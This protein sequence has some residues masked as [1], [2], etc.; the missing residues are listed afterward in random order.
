MRKSRAAYFTALLSAII[1]ITSCSWFN[2][3]IQSPVYFPFPTVTA[4]L[5]G[6]INITGAVPHEIL[7]CVNCDVQSRAASASRSA[8]PSVPSTGAGY[9]YYATVT[10][11]NGIKTWSGSADFTSLPAYSISGLDVDTL[12]QIEIGIK[13]DSTGNSVLKDTHTLTASTK[14]SEENPVYSHDFELKPMQTGGTTP[15]S[16]SIFLD[17][18]L[19]AGSE[20]TKCITSLSATEYNAGS[21]AITISTTA[22][23]G[24]YVVEFNFYS[25]ASE[26]LYSFTEAINVFDNLETDTWVRNGGT[27]SSPYLVEETDVSG[28]VTKCRITNA[29]VQAFRNTTLYVK[30]SG[31]NTNGTGTFFNPLQSI[32]GAIAKMYDK[33]LD[34]RI[35]VMDSPSGTMVSIPS[36]FTK[37]TNG[38]NHAKS[39]TICGYDGPDENGIPQNII[40]GLGVNAQPVIITFS[41]VPLIF[42]NLKL[43]N[44]KAGIDIYNYNTEVTL[45]DG[46]Y[47]TGNT[48][49]VKSNSFSM[50]GSAYIASDNAVSLETALTGVTYKIKVKGALT[51]HSSTDKIKVIPTSYTRGSAIVEADGTNV[52][53]LTSVKDCFEIV[54]T[55]W[56]T[57]LPADKSKIVINAPYFVAPASSA[58]S[59]Y[60]NG[61]DTTGDGS[62]ANPYESIYRVTNDIHYNNIALDYTIKVAGTIDGYQ[63]ILGTGDNAVTSANAA[64]ITIMGARPLLDTGKPQDWISC[65]S[66]KPVIRY[67]ATGVPLTLKNIC[68]TNGCT[69]LSLAS[70]GAVYIEEGTEITNNTY[71]LGGISSSQALGKG[72]CMNGG[73]LYLRGGEIHDNTMNSDDNSYAYISGGIHNENGIIYMSGGKIYKNMGKLGGGIYN[74]G[75]EVYIYGSAVIGKADATQCAQNNPTTNSSNRAVSGGGIYNTGTRTKDGNIYQAKVYIG[76]KPDEAGNIVVD[77]DFTGGIYY[78]YATSDGGAIY[79]Y[80]ST[81]NEAPEVHI[82]NGTIAY[83]S[84]QKGG[85]INLGGVNNTYCKVYL[86]GGVIKENYAS[87]STA[88]GAIHC[89]SGTFDVSLSGSV[90]IPA[91]VTN[92]E[93]PPVL[94]KGVGRNDIYLNLTNSHKLTVAGKLE[95]PAGSGGITATITPSSYTADTEVLALRTTPAPNP[96][97]T[98]DEA[99]ACFAVTPQVVGDVTTN[100]SV[101]EGKLSY[102][103]VSSLENAPTSGGAT[104]STKAEL[105]TVAAWV[106]D[107]HDLSGVTLILKENITIEPEDSTNNDYQIGRK[108]INTYPSSPAKPF[109]GT[110]D[111]NGKTITYNGS[112]ENPVAYAIFGQ[113]ESAVIKNINVAGTVNGDKATS[114]IDLCIGTQVVNCT[115]SCNVTRNQN[116]T[117]GLINEA[118]S[119]AS[120]GN[121]GNPV[122]PTRNC[123]IKD[124][125]FSG[126]VTSSGAYVGGL[127]GSLNVVNI[128]NCEMTGSVTGRSTIGGFFGASSYNANDDT[129]G[130]IIENSCVTGTITA[131]SGSAGGFAGIYVYNSPTYFLNCCYEGTVT[132]TNAAAYLGSQDW[133][134]TFERCYG[135]RDDSIGVAWP[136]TTSGVTGQSTW[137]SSTVTDANKQTIITRLN[138]KTITTNVD[139]AHT[140]EYL[141]WERGDDDKPRLVR[142]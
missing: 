123:E 39:L 94:V 60:G 134:A 87:L 21:N 22:T 138:E 100:W 20:I 114:L 101:I 25:S 124:C 23:S 28:T 65:G 136:T 117:G 76:Y 55:D 130:S 38:N 46:V 127:I 10:D 1:L 58:P 75:G 57:C 44:G 108:L 103:P 5:T 116:D 33:D 141:S 15:G 128:I 53:D 71:K 47:I 105:K 135:I 24:S 67:A 9:S 66:S 82:A 4:T 80:G 18:E 86:C 8:F 110:F 61:S 32:Q 52:T 41:N 140:S 125:V 50:K 64:S 99:S 81:A 113:T 16:G 6:D 45:D 121:Y 13:E 68:I 137:N 119:I 14:L 88:G 19:E 3:D 35:I 54:D 83:N 109:K 90:S 51:R 63:E 85:G 69:G 49:A 120:N 131:T 89:M 133:T 27:G 102:P 78:N 72:I 118:Y 104:I 122:I 34:Y 92:T 12:W 56:Y 107:G 74:K 139:Y 111:G 70:Y 84:S 26:I 98:L 31:G 59:G 11:T 97:T 93:T 29:M 96:S 2:D 126:T 42:K 129:K 132:A 48:V 30:Y 73:I 40:T 43:T 7:N 95:P 36:T 106:K 37:D 79:N 77:E 142:P 91:G 17:I 112:S 115:S 62:R